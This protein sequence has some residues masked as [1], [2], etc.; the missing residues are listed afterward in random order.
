MAGS[1]VGRLWD[2]KAPTLVLVDT[3]LQENGGI[4]PLWALQLIL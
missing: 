4:M 2:L 3:D 1:R